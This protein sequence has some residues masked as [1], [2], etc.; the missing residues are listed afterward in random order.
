MPTGAVT[1]WSRRP[2]CWRLSLALVCLGLSALAAC[3]GKSVGASSSAPATATQIP[4][5][6]ATAYAW[7]SA[8]AQALAQT[9]TAAPQ[10][11]PHFSDWRVAYL[12]AD[13]VV[14]A[15]SLDG[16]TDVNGPALPDLT[17]YGLNFTSAGIAPDGKT[18]AYA[19]PEL[20]LVDVTGQTSP[21]PVFLNG[22]FYDLRWS[23]DGSKL[24]TDTGPGQF[25]YLTVATGK[26]SSIAVPAEQD[27]AASLGWIDD[28]HIAVTS[29]RGATIYTDPSRNSSATSV[30]LVSLDI[31]NGSVRAIATVHGGPG[32]D[33]FE[34]SP[35]G[36]HALYYNTADNQL[37]NPS[38]TPHVDEIDIN[39]GIITSLPAITRL[40]HGDLTSVAWRPGSEQVAVSVDFTT[41]GDWL[42]DLRHDTATALGTGNLALAWSPDGT[43]LVLS[44]AIQTAIGAG[45]SELY[46]AAIA[47]SGP[48][49]TTVLTRNAMDFPLLGFVRNP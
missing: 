5:K 28:A 21:R 10:P 14:H 32:N 24:L 35:D 9:P 42:L 19:T 44:N 16:R 22:G 46:V 2:R 45:P 11:L 31:T 37:W 1:A 6:Y 20:D 12:G 29:Y 43:H 36:S 23:P 27:I 40:T 13:G 39:T 18:L 3:S 7:A 33:F 4:S 17:S 34:I 41:M 25:A 15:V 47:A 38:F 8:T 26:I 49:L 48:T 30:T